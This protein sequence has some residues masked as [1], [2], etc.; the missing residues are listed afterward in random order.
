MVSCCGMGWWKPRDFIC[1]WSK[2]KLIRKDW[3]DLR[4]VSALFKVFKPWLSWKYCLLYL[5]LPLVNLWNCIRTHS[6]RLISN[7]LNHHEHSIQRFLWFIKFLFQA[8]LLHLHLFL[9]IKQNVQLSSLQIRQL[10][11]KLVIKQQW[12]QLLQCLFKQLDFVIAIKNSSKLWNFLTKL[13]VFL[14]KM[15]VLLY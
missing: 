14:F 6:I 4:K 5:L 11:F 9:V 7:E 12:S 15:I 2:R 13:L 3:L 8:S 10:Q 1:C